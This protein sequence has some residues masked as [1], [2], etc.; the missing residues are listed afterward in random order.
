MN[1]KNSY[2][3][4]LLDA[5][6]QKKHALIEIKSITEKQSQIVKQDNFSFE[7]LD[8]TIEKKDEYIKKINIIDDGFDTT[9]DRI[10]QELMNN[11]DKYK[12][13]IIKLKTLI[14][15]IAEL[16]VEIQVIEQRNKNSLDI[17]F[18]QKKNKVKTFKKSKAMVSNYYK[19]M[20]NAHTNQAYFMDKKK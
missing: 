8:K 15:D 5:L 11:K 17:I 9:Y 13:S 7:D 12:D 10:R 2:I 16:G 18:S 6:Q 19:N 4:I 1:D 14:T 3:N 20:N